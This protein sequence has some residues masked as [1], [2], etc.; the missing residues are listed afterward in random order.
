[1]TFFAVFTEFN[2]FWSNIVTVAYMHPYT[3]LRI[4]NL[5]TFITKNNYQTFFILY[6]Q[7]LSKK[8]GGL[9]QKFCSKKEKKK[10]YEKICAN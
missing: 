6:I 9:Q 2:K 10:N 5:T 8:I 3:Y 7:K 4:L 1:M